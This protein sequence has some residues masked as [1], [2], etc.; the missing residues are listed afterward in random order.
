[1]VSDWFE[2]DNVQRTVKQLLVDALKETKVDFYRLDPVVQTTL[3]DEAMQVGVQH[4]LEPLLRIERV[5]VDFFALNDIDGAPD[6]A[7]KARVKKP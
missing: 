6:V 5:R 7:L 4:S 3:L 2:T 1:M